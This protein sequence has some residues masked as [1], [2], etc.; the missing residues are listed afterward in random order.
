VVALSRRALVMLLLLFVLTPVIV[1]A[2]LK[3]FFDQRADGFARQSATLLSMRELPAHRSFRDRR[4]SL[5]VRVRLAADPAPQERVF[6]L[7]PG[8]AASYLQAHHVGEQVQLWVSPK[9]MTITPPLRLRLFEWFPM[10]HIP[11]A[12]VAV[13]LGMLGLAVTKDVTQLLTPLPRRRRKDR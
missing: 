1:D 3:W 9:E 2:G 7:N 8:E 11:V 13:L 5:E 12:V 4:P 10:L 6:G